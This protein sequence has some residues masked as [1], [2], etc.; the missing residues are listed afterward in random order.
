M[1]IIQIL[2]TNMERTQIRRYSDINNLVKDKGK[3]PEAGIVVLIPLCLLIVTR[4]I[5]LPVQRYLVLLTTGTTVR[6]QVKKLLVLTLNPSLMI[7]KGSVQ[8]Y[9]E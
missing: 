7:F 5:Q 4:G 6:R 2:E 1:T 9:D 3:Q 8:G